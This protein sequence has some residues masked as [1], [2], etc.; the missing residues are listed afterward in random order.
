MDSLNQELATHKPDVLIVD[1]S[2]G[3]SFSVLTS[4]QEAAAETRIILWVNSISTELALQ[5]MAFGIRGFCEKRPLLKPCCAAFTALRK[6]SYGL[7]K[8]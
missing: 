8:P 3:I 5:A 7:K 6:A 1:L 4:L 2:A